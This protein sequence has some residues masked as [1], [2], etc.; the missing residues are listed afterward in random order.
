M[1]SFRA[2]T[3]DLVRRIVV[4]IVVSYLYYEQ[5]LAMNSIMFKMA[6]MAIE[7]SLSIQGRSIVQRMKTCTSLK[8][9]LPPRL[10]FD[11]ARN[12]NACQDPLFPFPVLLV[13]Q[14]CKR[15]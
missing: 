12:L 13:P 5:D 11:Q 4:R 7:I 14:N 10:E 1:A 15:P 8:S 2:K 6:K 3:K 9:Y